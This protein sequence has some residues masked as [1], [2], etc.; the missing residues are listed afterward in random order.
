MNISRLINEIVTREVRRRQLRDPE[1][2]AQNRA[3]Y[4]WQLSP[5]EINAIY[6]R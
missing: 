2:Y 6:W 4:L 1:R 5:E 3:E